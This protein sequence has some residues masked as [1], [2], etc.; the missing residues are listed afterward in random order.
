M[1]SCRSS[2][3]TSSREHGWGWGR[4]GRAQVSLIAHPLLG[5]PNSLTALWS[6]THGCRHRTEH[7]RGELRVADIPH[8]PSRRPR[9]GTGRQHPDVVHGPHGPPQSHSCA[10]G[11]GHRRRARLVRLRC[12]A[13]LHLGLD[14]LRG[15]GG[16]RRHPL[17]RRRRL[18]HVDGVLDEAGVAHD[19][20]RP[21]RQDVGGDRTR[22]DRCVHRSIARRGPRGPRDRLV[23]LPDIPSSRS[24]RRAGGRCAPRH[25]HRRRHRPAALPRRGLDESR[26]VLQ[27]HRRSI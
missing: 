10:V 24:G 9:G 11:G 19:R 23:P 26:G 3:D 6:P 27:A 17:D 12:T 4:T 7:P 5:L 20:G 1:N 2:S 13:A 8:R 14:E 18:R 25:P 22:H 21:A 16:V 15:A